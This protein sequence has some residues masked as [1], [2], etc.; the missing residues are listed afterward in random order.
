MFPLPVQTDVASTL[1][2]FDPCIQKDAV[3]ARTESKMGD[4]GS[5][6]VYVCARYKRTF[7]AAWQSERHYAP[8]AC[9][10][11]PEAERACTSLETLPGRAGSAPVFKDSGPCR[12]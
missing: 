12:Q 5:P 10:V 1:R 8:G 4:R 9:A 2:D 6:V 3:E 11:S 7:G